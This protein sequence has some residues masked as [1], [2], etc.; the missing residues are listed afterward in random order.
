MGGTICVIVI[1]IVFVVERIMVV[2]MHG[3]VFMHMLMVVTVVTSIAST[4][5][6]CERRKATGDGG[7]I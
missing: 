3:A 6:K 5:C 1:M 2:R 7:K 4:G